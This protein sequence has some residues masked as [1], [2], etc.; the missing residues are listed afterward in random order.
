M[1]QI[2][3]ENELF[4]LDVAHDRAYETEFDFVL[5]EQCF[6]AYMRLPGCSNVAHTCRDVGTEGAAGSLNRKPAVHPD[7]H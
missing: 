1:T 2:A 7:A 4:L 3:D 5:C 6:H